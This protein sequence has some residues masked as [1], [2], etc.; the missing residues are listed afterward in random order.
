MRPSWTLPDRAGI[1]VVVALLLALGPVYRVAVSRA[2]SVALTAT[3]QERLTSFD[4]PNGGPICT[5]TAT[6]LGHANRLGA[7]TEDLSGTVDTSTQPCSTLR[8]TRILT[9]AN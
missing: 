5:V 8:D 3:F 6:G 2:E 1:A 7:T 4:C 9:A